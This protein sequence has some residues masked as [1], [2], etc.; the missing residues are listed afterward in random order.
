MNGVL[1]DELKS[2][3][4]ARQDEFLDACTA[5]YPSDRVDGVTRICRE[6][7]RS[8]S[9]CY[10]DGSLRYFG[11]RSYDTCPMRELVLGIGDM[12]MDIGVS[13]S[14]VRRMDQ[15]PFSV[16]LERSF[17]NQQCLAF[18]NGILDL[19]A[20]CTSADAYD[21]Y[22]KWSGE[23]EDKSTGYGFFTEG[24]TK[25]KIAVE[26]MEYDYDPEATCP[27]WEAFLAEVLPNPDERKALQEFF[28]MVYMDRSK[29]SVEKFALLIGK[30]ANGKSVIFEVIKRAIGSDNV[31]TLDSAQL[32]DEK[33]IP[34][35]SG[36]RLNF[37]PDVRSSASFDSALKALAS[38][39]DV[40]GRRIYGDA[41]KIKCPPLCFALNELPRF[42]DVS[43]AFFR[44]IL[45]FK[46]DVVIPPE[47]QDKRLVEKIC[48]TDL[49]G[50][51][52]W[53]MEGRRRLEKRKGDFTQSTRMELEIS[54]MKHNAT[55]L[56]FPV[57]TYLNQRALSPRP[58]KPGQPYIKVS[59]NEIVTAM[60]GTLTPWAVTNQMT[61]L[62]VESVRN[63]ELYFKVYPK[64]DIK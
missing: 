11:G 21:A 20:A 4:E 24:F 12:L 60:Q 51:F 40:T 15:L 49:P 59:R 55:V 32:I 16:I 56:E 42:K 5:K 50:I 37:S 47:R 34:Y 45:L 17:E 64:Y 9:L 35:V 19:R 33:M 22:M 46:F 23:K 58:L 29:I 57:L 13:P 63:R 27:K 26:R 62:G 10:V 48:S 39:Q 28:G 30:G 36:K 14:D 54:I 41:E 1:R 31:T 3:I 18:K 61:R 25:E 43:D 6:V 8:S 44:R 38:G 52:N 7:I 2:M 53:L